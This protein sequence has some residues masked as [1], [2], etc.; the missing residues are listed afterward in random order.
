MA[1]YKV[2]QRFRLL[3][4][5]NVPDVGPIHEEGEVIDI[6][7]KRADQAIKTLGSSFLERVE[8]KDEDL[9]KIKEDALNQIKA[10]GLSEE[11]LKQLADGIE[12]SAEIEEV[13]VFVDTAHKL[14]EAAENVEEAK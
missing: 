11:D 1:Q 7:V 5:V 2:L 3:D 14:L 9:L 13:A 6:K 10:L 4:D 8:T 12:M